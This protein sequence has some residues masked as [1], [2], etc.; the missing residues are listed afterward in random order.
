MLRLLSDQN[1]NGDIVRGL[2]LRR[3]SLDLIRVQDIGLAQ[4]DDPTIL[5]WAATHNR[6]VVT[7]DRATMPS[8]AYD[9][10]VNDKAMPGVFILNDL[11]SVRQAI[12]AL[13]LVDE[14][15]EPTEWTGLVAYLP[16]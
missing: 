7:H 5:D 3:P 9:R 2:L 16:L 15:T 1:F 10:V 8:F 6:I 11:L 13:L 12:D 4:A 14:V